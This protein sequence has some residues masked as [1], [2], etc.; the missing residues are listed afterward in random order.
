MSRRFGLGAPRVDD[1]RRTV[2]TREEVPY[3]LIV[4]E[5]EKTEPLYFKSFRVP[6]TVASVEVVGVGANTI[7]V[8]EEAL[9]LRTGRAYDQ[10]WCVFDRDSFTPE[11]FN[12]AFELARSEGIFV[13]YSNEAFELWYLLHF[14]FC[15]AALSRTTYAAR[16]AGYLGRPYRKNDASMFDALL[17]RQGTAIRNARRLMGSYEPRR[18]AVDNP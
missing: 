9:R 2:G 8:V 5:G 15:D 13:A 11:R 3:Y 16:L 18:P 14:D 4:C 17:P 7:S 12:R 1:R 6:R 10:V